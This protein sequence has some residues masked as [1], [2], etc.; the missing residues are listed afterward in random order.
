VA[1]RLLV[2]IGPTASGKTHL[3]VDVAHRLGSEIISADSRQ[4]YRGLDIGAGKD[5]N[6]YAAVDPPVPFHLIDVEDPTEIYSLFRYQQDC[7]AV[8]EAK[9]REAPFSDGVPLVMV[10]GS[11]LY[12]EAVIQGYRIANV[13]EDVTFRNALMLR[14]HDD[15][16]TE[17]DR[18]GSEITQ[19]T[20]RTSKKRV[21]RALEIAHY[22]VTNPVRYSDPPPVAIEYAV[23][24]IVVP[25]E[26]LHRRIDTRLDA[27]MRDGLISEVAALL[28]AGVSEARMNQLGLEYREVTAYLTGNKTESQMVDDLRRGIR[29]FAKRQRTR[30]RGFPRRGIEVTWIGPDD[31]AA[32]LNHEFET[33]D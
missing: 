13:P 1:I 9:N 26:E 28:D 6:E 22:A 5:L 2:V 17:F 7:Y 10:G 3:G 16:L 12:V 15:L 29:Q 25:R 33:S 24:G 21:V 23:F 19:H 20:D 18:L 27:R 32:L 31:H 11:G 30:F 14:D 8:L 4:S